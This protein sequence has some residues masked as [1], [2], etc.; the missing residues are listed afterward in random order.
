MRVPIPHSDL[1]LPALIRRCPCREDGVVLGRT[2]VVGHDTAIGHGTVIGD[3]AQVPYDLLL[4]QRLPSIPCM[5]NRE[6]RSCLGAVVEHT[7]VI[8][9]TAPLCLG[10]S[11]KIMH[12]NHVPPA[13]LAGA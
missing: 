4:W 8:S 9:V 11:L 1:P 5:I 2:A 12:M 6:Q 3:A 7:A 13:A 10:L